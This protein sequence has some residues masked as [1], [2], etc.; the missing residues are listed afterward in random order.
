MGN[1]AMTRL[2]RWNIII[3]ICSC[4]IIALCLLVPDTEDAVAVKSERE[5]MRPEALFVCQATYD[6]MAKYDAKI[7]I[8]SPYTVFETN[9]GWVFKIEGKLQNGFGAWLKVL[10]H[11]EVPYKTDYEYGDLRNVAKFEFLPYN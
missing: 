1:G 11:C 9:D 5:I 3:F 7:G 2:Q 6:A 4:G 10:A 8:L